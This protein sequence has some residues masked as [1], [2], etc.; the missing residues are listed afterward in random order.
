LSASLTL[1]YSA[2]LALSSTWLCQDRAPSKVARSCWSWARIEATSVSH[3]AATVRIAAASSRAFCSTTS[4][5]RSVVRT[6]A[7][8][9]ASS[10][11][12]ASCS[13]SSSAQ[14]GAGTPTTHC[15]SAGPRQGCQERHIGPGTSC[16]RSLASR[17]GRTSPGPDPR[18]PVT[19]GQGKREMESEEARTRERRGG[20]KLQIPTERTR[21]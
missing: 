19:G 20:K 14:P 6:F 3:F 1:S 21:T 12:W 2:P 4:R 9:E 13:R 11:A 5:S 8:A 16:A 18:T 10:A 15:R 17:G 7:T